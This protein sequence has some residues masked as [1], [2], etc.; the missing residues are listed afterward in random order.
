MLPRP[1]LFL[2]PQRILAQSPVDMD[3]LSLAKSHCEQM[4]SATIA[5]IYE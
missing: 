3:T 4:S 2:C 5:V 1:C